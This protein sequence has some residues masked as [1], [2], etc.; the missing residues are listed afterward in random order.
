MSN[1]LEFILFA[2]DTNI[3][4][5]HKDINTLSTTFNQ[6]ITKLSDCCRANNLSLNLKKSNSM[7]F[8]PRQK[9]QNF[10][11]A[12]SIDGI[13]LEQAKETVFLGVVIDEI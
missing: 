12:F 13:P 2:D 3:F 8:K 6:E 9:R 10:E 7:V 4:Y 5:S 11:L 1:V